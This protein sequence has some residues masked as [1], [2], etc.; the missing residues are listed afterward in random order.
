MSLIGEIEPFVMGES[1]REYLERMDI[2]LQVNEVEPSKKTIM[3]LTL[4]GASLYSLISKL[5]LPEQPKTVNYEKLC[6]KLQEQLE[7]KV[8][9]VAERFNFRNCLQKDR[10]VAEYIVELKALAQS[11]KFTS[12]LAQCLRDQL[13]AGVRD[14]G[15]RKRLLRES[16]LTFESAE[17]IARTWE[18]ADEQNETFAAKEKPREM[19]V[20]K[21]APKRSVGPKVHYYRGSSTPIHQQ[22]SAHKQESKCYR[23]GRAHNPQTCPARMWQC[24]TCKKYGHVSSCCRNTNVHSLRSE[25]RDVSLT[26]IFDDNAISSPEVC[27]LKVNEKDVAFEIDCG[28][29]NTVIPESVYN[30][31][32]AN[33]ELEQTHLRFITASGQRVVPLGKICVNVSTK[34]KTV[35]LEITVIATENKGNPLLGRDAL[36][37]LFPNWR[38]SFNLN[39]IDTDKWLEEIKKNVSEFNKRW[40]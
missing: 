28:A 9:V 23:C 6:I 34:S 39:Q 37:I 35:S 36:D 21:C 27:V 31:K 32:F 40:S 24:F 3:L 15:L 38:K 12:C 30:E 2:F 29:C 17:N 7:Q 11:C 20:I 8:N 33:I 22:S 18:A 16:D 14:E 13:V 5:V 1:I 19:A 4:G 10:S 26:R 25:Y